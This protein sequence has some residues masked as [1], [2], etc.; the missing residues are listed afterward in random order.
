[1]FFNTYLLIQDEIINIDE[2]FVEYESLFALIKQQEPDSVEILALAALLHSFY[3][4]LENIFQLIAKRFDLYTPDPVGWHTDLLA[5]MGETTQNRK[6]VLQNTT[7][8]SLHEYLGF[9]HF[10]RHSYTNKIEWA[11]LQ[12]LVDN[13]YNTWINVKSELEDFIE[14]IQE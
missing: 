10:F 12:P 11:K 3:N 8:L 7:L 4:G 2:M 6:P 14:V 1:V 5:K 9:R 13:A